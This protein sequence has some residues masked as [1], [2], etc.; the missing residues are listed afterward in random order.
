MLYCLIQWKYKNTNVLIFIWK[1]LE[2]DSILYIYDLYRLVGKVVALKQNL[3]HL[4][5]YFWMFL[6]LFLTDRRISLRVLLSVPC[7]F[8]TISKATSRSLFH[9]PLYSFHQVMLIIIHS[10]CGHPLIS[11]HVTLLHLSIP[12]KKWCLV[13]WCFL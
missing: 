1:S 6:V 2:T 11:F 9:C 13:H 8:P 10:W 5:L 4:Q 7:F 3:T 12:W